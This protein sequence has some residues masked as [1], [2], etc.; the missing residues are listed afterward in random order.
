[1][2]DL[3]KMNVNMIGVFGINKLIYLQRLQ[4]GFQVHKSKLE[5]E[6]YITKL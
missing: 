5:K 1:M 4:D 6:L 2:E 3:S